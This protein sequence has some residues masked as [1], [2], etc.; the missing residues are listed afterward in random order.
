[1]LGNK[2]FV[3]RINI[4]VYLHHLEC[5]V[6]YSCNFPW[7]YFLTFFFQCT[8]IKVS[9]VHYI[10]TPTLKVNLYNTKKMENSIV[11]CFYQG[12]A[13]FI[14]G[15]NFP[16]KRNFDTHNR[17]CYRPKHERQLLYLTYKSSSYFCNKVHKHYKYDNH[18]AWRIHP[19]SSRLHKPGR[20]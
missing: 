20:L 17:K 13:F 19:C 18:I 11:V 14:L 8:I 15:M 2:K 3:F 1:M 12:I 10:S 9:I 6:L 4:I 5:Q 16:N 7:K